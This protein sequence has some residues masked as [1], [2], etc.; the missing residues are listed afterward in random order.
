M[1]PVD[2]GI[3]YIYADDRG[4][5]VYSARLQLKLPVPLLSVGV[6]PN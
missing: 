6:L 2:A 5:G 1:V 3:G 4:R